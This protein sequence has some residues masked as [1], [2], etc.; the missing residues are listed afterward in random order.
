MPASMFK[1]SLRIALV[2]DFNPAVIAHQA[3]PQALDNAALEIGVRAD[4]DWLPTPEVNSPED[5]VGYDA[6]W[7]VPASPYQHD[8]GA[9]IAIRYARENGIPFLGTCGGFQYSIVEYARNVMGWKDAGHAETES[10][11]RLVIV[12]LV[13]SLVEKSDVINLAPGS[14]IAA[15]Y[16]R[17][18]IE[19][20][21]RCSYGISEQFAEAPGQQP[22]AATGW[23]NQGAI[24]AVELTDHPFFV[25]TLFQHER[26][27]LKGRPAPLVEA[28]LRAARE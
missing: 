2:G 13:C 12:P 25:G 26:N 18:E 11:G 19:E 7:C 8:E 21:Y 14:K 20:G 23:D 1:P 5:L 24:R 15:A 9:F 10:E 22:L 27:A 28:M 3:I 16:G 6:I 4:Y 17:E